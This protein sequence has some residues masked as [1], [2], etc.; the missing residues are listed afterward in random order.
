M[1]NCTLVF[2]AHKLMKAHKCNIHNSKLGV[3]INPLKTIH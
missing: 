2:I 1:C 3:V